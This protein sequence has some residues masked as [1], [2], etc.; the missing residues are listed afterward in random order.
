MEYRYLSGAGP[1]V[2]E[3]RNAFV[4]ADITVDLPALDAMVSD[5]L[6]A[7]EAAGGAR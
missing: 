5:L 7:R 2:K 1:A 6:A 4:V 3:T